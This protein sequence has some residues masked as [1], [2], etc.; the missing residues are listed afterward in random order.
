MNKLNKFFLYVLLGSLVSLNS[1]KDDEEVPTFTSGFE[2]L[3]IPEGAVAYFGQDK[4]GENKGEN[5][6]GYTQYETTYSSGKAVY[7]VSYLEKAEDDFYFNGV[8]YSKATDNT[9][10]G[11][12]GRNVAITGEGA[13][14]S[15]TYG[16]YNG[17]APVTFEYENGARPKSIQITNNAYAYSSM[18]KGDQYAKKFGGTEGTDPDFFRLTIIGLDANDE[19]TGE[20]EFLLADYRFD[21]N[22]KDYIVDTWERVD[23][24]PLG[25]VSKLTFKLESSDTGEYGMN[26]PAYFAF[27]NLVSQAAETE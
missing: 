26:T 25:T 17:S 16:I 7:V 10:E 19:K 18:M 15:E 22:T 14:N 6:Y 24:S 4:S 9:L 27:D 11:L 13:D 21:D 23:L 3:E 12:A 8:V 1:C 2:D 20:V 5:D